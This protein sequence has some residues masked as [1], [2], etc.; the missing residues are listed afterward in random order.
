MDTVQRVFT[1]TMCTTVTKQSLHGMTPYQTVHSSVDER[2]TLGACCT[3]AFSQACCFA[4]LYALHMGP[5]VPTMPRP[6]YMH[7]TWYTQSLSF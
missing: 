3:P 6:L 7:C 1:E 2:L 5:R 4:A